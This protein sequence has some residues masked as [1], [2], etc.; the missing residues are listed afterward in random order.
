MPFPRQPFGQLLAGFPT[1]RVF[2]CLLGSESTKSISPSLWQ[3]GELPGGP[4]S[5]LYNSLGAQPFQNG[6]PWLVET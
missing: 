3:P 2:F 6:L 4:P 5:D 1:T